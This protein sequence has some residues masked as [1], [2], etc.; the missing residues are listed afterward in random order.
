MNLK[1]LS[2]TGGRRHTLRQALAEQAANMPADMTK[3]YRD[4]IKQLDELPEGADRIKLMDHQVSIVKNALR[5]H[6]C[7]AS[8]H[9]HDLVC[10]M[11]AQLTLTR[12]AYAERWRTC[13]IAHR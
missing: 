13:Y 7:G 8:I 5:Q 6:D 4:T 11:I 10:D 3:P 9:E 2:L 12:K 1:K